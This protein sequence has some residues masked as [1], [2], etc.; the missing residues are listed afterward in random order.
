M[1]RHRFTIDELRQLSSSGLFD[2]RRVELLDGDLMDVT[3]NPP[4]AQAVTKLQKPFERAFGDRAVVYSQNP[5]DL[6]LE[7]YLPQPDVMLIEARDYFSHPRAADVLLLVEVA[8]ETLQKDRVV[9]M[10]LYARAGIRE[11]WIA[12]LNQRT[13][14]VYRQPQGKDYTEAVAY[15]FEEAFAPAAFPDDLAPWLGA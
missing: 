13:W 8:D 7:H 4:H 9:K 15:R 6:G 3:I 5:L 11:Y 2:D 1:R 10:P 12:D 14:Y